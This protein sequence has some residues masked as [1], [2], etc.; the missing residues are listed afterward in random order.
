MH[1]NYIGVVYFL[2]TKMYLFRES[3]KTKQEI[4][5]DLRSRGVFPL[6]DDPKVEKFDSNCITP[7]SL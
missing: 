5:A 7:V 2:E 3:S 1:C 6:K 4:I